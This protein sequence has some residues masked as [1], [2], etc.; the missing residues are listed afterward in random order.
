MTYFTYRNY[1]VW[2]VVLFPARYLYFS[3]ALVMMTTLAPSPQPGCRNF[4]SIP[5]IRKLDYLWAYNFDFRVLRTIGSHLPAYIAHC[6]LLRKLWDEQRCWLLFSIPQPQKKKKRNN[7]LPLPSKTQKKMP[8][9]GGEQKE[10]NNKTEQK[11]TF[12]ENTPHPFHQQR[13]VD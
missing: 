7:P 3:F 1:I 10:E 4:L 9:E 8:E 12:K 5:C 13:Y 6:Y 2:M 11:K